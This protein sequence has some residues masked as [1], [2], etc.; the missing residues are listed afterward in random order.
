VGKYPSLGPPYANNR[1]M[2]KVFFQPDP[3]KGFIASFIRPVS[4]KAVAPFT[5][6]DGILMSSMTVGVMLVMRFLLAH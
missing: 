1:G 5:M 2:K 3:K 4:A 6:F